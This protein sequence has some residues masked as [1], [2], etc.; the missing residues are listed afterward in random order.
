[1]F[2]GIVY[3]SDKFTFRIMKKMKFYYSKSAIYSIALLVFVSLFVGC[4]NQPMTN[5]NVTTNT[6]TNTI[7][8]ANANVANAA[9]VNNKNVAG[10]PVTLPVL[11]AIFFDKVFLSN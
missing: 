2:K 10:L 4:E 11:D 9:P 7:T 1:M 5:T 6:N 3:E 8:T